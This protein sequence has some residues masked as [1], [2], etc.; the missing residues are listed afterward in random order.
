MVA[1]RRSWLGWLVRCEVDVSGFWGRIVCNES[2]LYRPGQ[3]ARAYILVDESFSQK[4]I[5]PGV[6]VGESFPRKSIRPGVL[7]DESFSRRS[8]G[9]G[10]LVDDSF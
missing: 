6:L 5:R 3:S 8:I 9:A 4:S 7:V 10:V 2:D 1:S